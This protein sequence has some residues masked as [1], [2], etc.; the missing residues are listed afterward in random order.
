MS[1]EHRGHWSSNERRLM[2]VC[3]VLPSPIA[4]DECPQCAL[5]LASRDSLDWHLR[6]DHVVDEENSLT[7][8]E[9]LSA[10]REPSAVPRTTEQRS[11]TPDQP[12]LKRA[13]SLVVPPWALAA[14]AS[15]V[16]LVGLTH[17][18]AGVGR[19]LLLWVLSMACGAALAFAAWKRAELRSQ[20]I[21]RQPPP[22]H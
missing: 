13:Q 1:P 15:V 8:A 3:E 12:A 10:P 2:E 11:A 16:M 4:P 9:I 18:G 22:S 21:R 5:R 6:L 17:A 7:V 19:L 20:R 14:L